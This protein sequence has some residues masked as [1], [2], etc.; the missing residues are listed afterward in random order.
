MRRGEEVLGLIMSLKQHSD[1]PSEIE[2][3]S[4]EVVDCFFSVHKELGPG[5]LEKIYEDALCHEFDLRGLKF[6]RQMPV[7]VSY[8]GKKMPTDYRI[9]IIVDNTIIVEL[10]AVD[11]VLPVHEAQILSYMK[12][13]GSPLGLIANFNT[14]LMEDGIKRVVL[15]NNLRSFASSR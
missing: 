3:L 15:T 4:K 9:D 12:L 13:T 1:M 14:T 2:R 5:L 7:A 11:R 8:K 10:K 6:Q